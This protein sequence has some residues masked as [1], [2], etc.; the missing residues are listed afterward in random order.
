M[1]EEHAYHRIVDEAPPEAVP[2]IRALLASESWADIRLVEHPWRVYPGGDSA[3]NVLGYVAASV[4]ASAETPARTTS[5]S[6]ARTAGLAGIERLA[7]ASLRGH[8][9]RRVHWTNHRGKRLGARATIDPVDGRDLWLT[10]DTRLQRAAESLLDRAIAGRVPDAT[11]LPTGGA[12]VV[13][14]IRSG[15]LLAAASAPRFDPNVFAH[16]DERAVAWLSAP[17]QPMFDRV[18]RMAIPP[19]SVFKIVTAIALLE[20]GVARPETSYG[21][22]GYLEEPD[23][24]RCALFR[25]QGIG[26]GEVRLAEALAMSCNTYFFHFA[27]SLG[28]EPLVA[29][30]ERFG[31]GRS[32]NSGLA[33]EAAGRMATPASLARLANRAWQA[34]DTESLAIGQGVFTATPLQVATWIAAVGNG[35]Y[36]VRP[37]IERGAETRSPAPVAPASEAP[38]GRR[39]PI[40]PS[41]LAAVR[42]GLRL[43]IDDPLGTGHDARRTWPTL[44][45]KTGTAEIDGQAEHAWFASYTPAENPRWVI[46]VALEHGGSGATA[47]GP[48][49]RQLAESLDRLE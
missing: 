36:W 42:E 16:G 20:Q 33:D 44:A 39:L 8:P 9:G 18:A 35:G 7:E 46:V 12:A 17:G 27:D 29:W 31:A 11:D 41:A 34:A 21:C 43:A 47:A 23:R 14:D 48:I 49:V 13:M 4:D 15:E 32:T 1:A 37:H 26:H 28:P 22:R 40:S 5:A 2:A 45:G 30:A 25:R 3:A 24:M 38:L 10:L 6:V 19:G